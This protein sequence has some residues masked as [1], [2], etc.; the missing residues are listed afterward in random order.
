MTRFLLGLTA[1]ASIIF[2]VQPAH[3]LPLTSKNW[4]APAYTFAL[5]STFPVDAIVAMSNCSASLVKFKGVSDDASAIVLTNGHCTGGKNPLNPFQPFL[6]PGE[7]HNHVQRN[8][9]MALLDKNASQVLSISAVEVIYATMTETDFGL[10]RLDKTYAEL[11]A[12]APGIEPLILSDVHPAAGTKIQIP[13]GYWKKTYSCTISKFIGELNEGGYIWH[14]SIRYS[15]TG[16]NVIGGTSGSPILNADTGEI[17][18][19]NNTTNEDGKSCEI[20]NPCEQNSDGTVVV[21]KGASYGQETYI[22]YQC[23]D[24][25]GQFDLNMPTCNLPKGN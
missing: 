6:K 18:G 24:S 16:C 14:D 4:K 8:F 2:N 15:D 7:V 11:R 21:N 9:R 3:A 25:K 5:Q 1:L 20:N 17:I 13:S 22:L 10:L 12:A 23:L 19:I